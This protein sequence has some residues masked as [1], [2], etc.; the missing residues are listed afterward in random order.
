MKSEQ[1]HWR[2]ALESAWPVKRAAHLGWRGQALWGLG[3]VAQQLFAARLELLRKYAARQLGGGRQ[4]VCQLAAR[5][6]HGA[7]G[8]LVEGQQLADLEAQ[9]QRGLCHQHTLYSHL[10]WQRGEVGTVQQVRIL[11]H[12]KDGAELKGMC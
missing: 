9:Q 10:P 6:Q 12:L 3:R 7:D 2:H 8:A 1:Q 5:A 11:D 4:G